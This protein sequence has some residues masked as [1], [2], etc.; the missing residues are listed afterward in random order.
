MGNYR[1]GL[2]YNDFYLAHHGIKGQ[3]WGV[4]RFQNLDRTWTEA[5]K[6]RYGR[7]GNDSVYG[8]G[9]KKKEEPSS[10]E[11][12]KDF[13][14]KKDKWGAAR[15]IGWLLFDIATLNP[16]ALAM[17]T[18]NIGKTIVANHK[19]DTVSKDI[20]K[21]EIDP[22][23]GLHIKNHEYT[24]KEDLSAVN[25]LYGD[26]SNDSKNNCG[27]CTATYEMRR[28]GY[29]VKAKLDTQGTYDNQ[30]SKWFKGAKFENVGDPSL[31]FNK[32]LFGDKTAKTYAESVIDDMKKYPEGSRGDI[33]VQWLAFGSGH[34]MF[35]EIQNGN[36]VIRDAQIAKTYDD[37]MK[38]L[39]K[40][41][42]VR[43]ARIDN[44]DFYPDHVKEF[45]E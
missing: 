41:T 11:E 21:S 29:N 27:L 34:S 16:V 7:H 39:K 5:G 37:P 10:S 25:P 42:N 24:E 4:R 43:V 17:D 38:V 30:L 19:D 22:K 44:L 14:A 33:H 9:K 32:P 12:P 45:C 35:W 23:T 1:L 18:V 2:G 28:R 6:E 3:K 20:D 36:L 40:T 13:E 26:W 15:Q 31:K 8:F